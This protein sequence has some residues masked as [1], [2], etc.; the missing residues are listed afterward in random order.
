M[1]AAV[2]SQA[3]SAQHHHTVPSSLSHNQTGGSQQK[4]AAIDS[5]LQ[6]KNQRAVCCWANTSP[7]WLLTISKHV[8]GLKNQVEERVRAPQ[9]AILNAD[10][11]RS[12][13]CM[14]QLADPHPFLAQSYGTACSTTDDPIDRHLLEPPC[15]KQL[16]SGIP[17][18]SILQLQGSILH[19]SRLSIQHLPIGTA[20]KLSGL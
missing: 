11:C 16:P 13:H 12:L 14:D 5:V 10:Q 19:P 9:S 1:P 2:L 17:E 8:C 15:R 3:P 18:A 7:F 20:I 4:T 6:K